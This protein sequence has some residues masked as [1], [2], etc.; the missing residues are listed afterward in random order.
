M[1][2]WTWIVIALSSAIGFSLVVGLTVARVLG[3]IGREISDILEAEAEAWVDAPPLARATA[4]RSVIGAEVGRSRA[5]GVRSREDEL[6][7][8]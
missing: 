1:S 8:V 4:E 7:A 2:V 3:S 6:V 5:D